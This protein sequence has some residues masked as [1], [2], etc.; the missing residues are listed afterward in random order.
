M[1]H[2]QVRTTTADE[3]TGGRSSASILG[4]RR[5]DG[6]DKGTEVMTMLTIIQNLKI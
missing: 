4:A 6:V 1:A 5:F 2:L 3:G